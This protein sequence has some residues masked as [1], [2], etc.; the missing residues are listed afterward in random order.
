MLSETEGETVVVSVFPAGAVKEMTQTGRV[1]FEEEGEFVETVVRFEGL[2]WGVGAV[3]ESASVGKECSA[4]NMCVGHAKIKNGAKSAIA[5]RPLH[6]STKQEY[7][8]AIH[9]F[10]SSAACK[11]RKSFKASQD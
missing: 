1:V 4:S 6:P 10:H 9:L 2:G 7:K 3:I 11:E 8:E 5:G